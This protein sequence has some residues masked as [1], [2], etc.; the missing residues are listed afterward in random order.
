MHAYFG[1]PYPSGGKPAPIYMGLPQVPAPVD[2]WCLY[3]EEP[4]AEG[5]RGFLLPHMVGP[6]YFRLVAEHY[7]CFMRQVLG[8]VAHQ[9]S[10]CSC[11]VCGSHHMD[12]PE[13]TR[14]DAARAALVEFERRWQ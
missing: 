11:V 13:L 10:R 8:S 1:E 5:D 4:I 2:D 3:C 6:N 7:E 12:D 14:R 9:Q